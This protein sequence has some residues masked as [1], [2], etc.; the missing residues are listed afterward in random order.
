M[1]TS[2]QPV[3]SA[4]VDFFDNR[5]WIAASPLSIP[6]WCDRDAYLPPIEFLNACPAAGATP[7]HE[8]PGLAAEF[9]IARLAA[10][11]ETARL[12][13]GNFKALGGAYAVFRFAQQRASERI[14][15]QISV[16]EMLSAEIRQ[17]LTGSTVCCATD[18]NHGRSVAAGASLLGID[19]VIF[20][21]AGV[22]ASRAEAIGKLGARIIRVA[23]SYE[24]SV[25][26]AASL[27]TEKGWTLIADTA[28]VDSDAA[29]MCGYV[30]Q[31]YTVLVHEAMAQESQGKPFTHIFVQAGVGGLAAVVMGHW[32]AATSSRSPIFVTVEPN[33][34]ACLLASARAGELTQVGDD[35]PT[36]MSMLECQR[37]SELAWPIVSRLASFFMQIDDADAVAAKARLESPHASDPIINA[38]ES[39]AAGLAGLLRASMDRDAW[40]RLGLGLDSSVLV[41]VT[42]VSDEESHRP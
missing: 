3:G 7:M 18:G 36:I 40:D 37:P 19:C 30:M 26:Y 22:P 35:Q 20:L 14:G 5:A 39:G 24:D 17:V 12:G 10:K 4:D 21:H 11:D 27:G 8:L 31:G 29:Q 33:R 9:G 41:L 23:G 13:F 15:R 32:T 16:S 34:S 38:G 42:E 2:T 25:R 1:I 28:P 6:W